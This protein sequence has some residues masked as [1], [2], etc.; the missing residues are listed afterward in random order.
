MIF[1][2]TQ[3]KNILV[4]L[5]LLLLIA[6]LSFSSSSVR[7]ATQISSTTD[8]CSG[9]SLD[10]KLPTIGRG[11][12]IDEATLNCQENAKKQCEKAQE[13][14]AELCERAEECISEKIPPS[15][16]PT[17]KIISSAC[18]KVNRRVNSDGTTTIRFDRV[19]N[20]KC[21][22]I[23]EIPCKA[24]CKLNPKKQKEPAPI[25]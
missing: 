17:C 19:P 25:S 10:I 3:T 21:V 18:V 20:K 11:A 24:N 15:E 22:A 6:S 16:I 1:F 14:F 12:T 13:S 23:G 2:K 7:A 9:F 4:S 5:T 8:I